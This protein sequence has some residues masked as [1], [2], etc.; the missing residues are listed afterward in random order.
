MTVL[1]V[2]RVDSNEIMVKTALTAEESAELARYE[3]VIDR[4]RGKVTF[5]EVGRALLAVRDGRLYRA[6]YGTFEAYCDQR[7]GMS[8]SRARQLCIAAETVTTVTVDGGQLP[9]NEAQAR[10]LAMVPERERAEVWHEAV[11]RSHGKPTASTIRLIHQE[12]YQ[13][14]VEVAS[15]PAIPLKIENITAQQLWEQITDEL[16][17]LFN[18]PLTTRD[19]KTI[20]SGLQEFTAQA[21]VQSKEENGDE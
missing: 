14:P 9:A 5:V 1:P 7:W 21:E 19:W 17:I 6:E 16:N 18:Q 3:E 15:C 8:D 20:T 4:S 2:R 12:H 13:P 11:Q 10:A